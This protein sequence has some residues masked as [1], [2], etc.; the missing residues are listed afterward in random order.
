MKQTPPTSRLAVGFRLTLFAYLTSVFCPYR[1]CVPVKGPVDSTWF[2]AVNYAAA[3]HLVIGRDIF[4]TYGPLAY[5]LVPFDIGNNLAWALAAQT[6]LWVLF[7]L[8]VWDLF[9]SSRFP[10]RNLLVFSILLAL[11]ALNYQQEL[12]PGNLLLCSALIFLVHFHLRG[13]RARLLIASIMMGFMPLISF[14]AAVSAAAIIGGFLVDRLLTGDRTLNREVTL[15]VAVVLLTASA[16]VWYALGS[17]HAMNGYARSSL[18]LAAGYS[19]AMSRSQALLPFAVVLTAFFVFAVVLTSLIFLDP[20][21]ARFFG[22][23]LLI[24]ILIALRHSL[25]RA[26]HYHVIQFFSFAAL[27]MAL[28]TLSISFESQRARAVL[29]TAMSLFGILWLID[30]GGNDL[31]RTLA[32]L[33]GLRTPRL[34]WNALHYTSMRRSLRDLAEQNFPSSSRIEPDI[35]I[36]IGEERVAF[37]SNEFSNASLEGL[38][39][40][41]SPVFQRYSAYTPYLDGLN[42][43][44]IANAGPRYLLFDGQAL[45]ARQ[46]WTESPATWLE[47]YRWYSKR[48]LGS[49]NLLLQRRQQPRFYDLERIEQRTAS[50][51]TDITIP[52]S[53]NPVF[54]TM[55]C[56]LNPEGKVRAFLY[57]IPE[58]TMTVATMNAQTTTYRAIIPVLV[59]PS[60][61][62]YLPSNLEQFGEVFDDHPKFDLSVK[63]LK[64]SGPGAVAYD[65]KC[66]L[67]FLRAVPDKQQ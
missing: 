26:D 65:H 3:H 61:G 52:E 17:F 45:D 13:G 24:P 55:E 36:L 27:G 31:Q 42:A 58:V 5:L 23:T 9:L 44:W 22:L 50:F 54:W 41:L 38:N 14:I 66:H 56:P 19:T 49:H 63:K 28:I 51:G 67:T 29:V 32:A 16:S 12:Y 33:G 39:L 4:W 37:L 21:N 64:F 35:R 15:S 59:H 30:V 40:A 11:T 62:N 47:V 53:G 2:F 25:V 1:Y 60:L 43:H 6:A 57:R 48:A 8:A 7:A 20:R 18:E 10:F 34:V 46:P